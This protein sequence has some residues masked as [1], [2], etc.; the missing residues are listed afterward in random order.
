LAVLTGRF[1]LSVSS[2]NGSSGYA[3]YSAANSQYGAFAHSLADVL[4]YRPGPFPDGEPHWWRTLAFGL[5]GAPGIADGHY[6]WV[7]RP[8][9]ARALH[10]MRWA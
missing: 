4:G 9:L 2:L 3:T 8:E 5:D 10:Q 7:M 6:R 1:G